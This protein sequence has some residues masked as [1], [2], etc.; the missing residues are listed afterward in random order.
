MKLEIV[1]EMMVQRNFTICPKGLGRVSS[2]TATEGYLIGVN[3]NNEYIYIKIF[4]G[5]FVLQDVREFLYSKFTIIDNTNIE[6]KNSGKKVVQ[7]IIICKSY[8]NSHLKEF[9]QVIKHIQLIRS[10]FFNINITRKAPLHQKVDS[11]LIKNKREIAIIKE[12]D[13]NCVFYNFL[14]GDVIRVTRFDGEICYRLV[15]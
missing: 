11:N 10:D 7:L 4:E 6:L 2:T 8:Q 13:P 12:D 9:K 14:K 5:K 3:H 15:K 1:K